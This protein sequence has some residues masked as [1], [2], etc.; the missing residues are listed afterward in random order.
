[1]KIRKIFKTLLC[2]FAMT[3]VTQVAAQNDMKATVDVTVNCNDNGPMT[4]SLSKG[5]TCVS[6]SMQLFT[7]DIATRIGDAVL[8]NYFSNQK[9]EKRTPNLK[10]AKFVDMGFCVLPEKEYTLLTLGYDKDGAAGFVTRTSF[11]TPK[12]KLAG[13][14]RLT[15]TVT[16]LGP[17]S[18]TVKF[19]PNADVAGYAICQFEAGSIDSIVAH[20]GPMMGFSNP[21]D[22][23]RRFSGQSAY[24]KEMSHTWDDMTPNYDYEICA[25]PWDKDGVYLDIVTTPVKTALLG[26]EGVAAVNIEIGQFGGSDDT[27][28]FQEIVYT[29]NDQAAVHRDIIITEEAFNAKDMG[30]R[31]VIDMLQ[32]D[33]PQDPY[34]NQYRVDRAKWNALPATTYIACSMARNVKGEWGKLH[35]KKF[36]TPAKQ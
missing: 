7:S 25:L 2:L 1:M 14:P 20:H 30:E 36:T 10:D 32:K 27:G 34:W 9:T 29:P 11:T 35:T 26:G 18:V 15:C 33:I 31:G 6:Y 12:H 21:S 8:A 13:N 22:M 28:Y 16:A 23:I 17:D 4:L 19:S 24:T 5:T 3:V